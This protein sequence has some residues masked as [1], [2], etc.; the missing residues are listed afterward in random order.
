MSVEVWICAAAVGTFVVITVTAIAAFCQLRHLRTSNQQESLLTLGQRLNDNIPLIS[1][2]YFELPELMNSEEFRR[3]IGLVI[4][5]DHHPELIV[6]GFFDE[7]GALV[8]NRMMDESLLMEFGGGADSILW[9]WK[10]LAGVIAIRRRN[11]PA[12]YE[13]FEF[14]ASRAK[15]W[16]ER[17]PKGTYPAREP[18]MPLPPEKPG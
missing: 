11:A 17:F 7:L 15:R 1:F 2:V 8:K 18:R 12:A 3:D 13:N 5:R 6:A 4:N 14:I 10:N 9:C 16:K